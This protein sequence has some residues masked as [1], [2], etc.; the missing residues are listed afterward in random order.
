M[1]RCGHLQPT[2]SKSDSP[3]GT[4]SNDQVGNGLILRRR[5]LQAGDGQCI[6]LPR[7]LLAAEI[8]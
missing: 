5:P 1:D 2:I 3:V 6:G 4:R 7:R 8:A